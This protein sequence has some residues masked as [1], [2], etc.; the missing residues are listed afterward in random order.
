MKTVLKC[1]VTKIAESLRSS[2][3]NLPP[4]LLILFCFVKTRVEK[5]NFYCLVMLSDFHS[6]NTRVRLS[7][8]CSR[9]HRRSP[10]S[11]DI[12]MSSTSGGHESAPLFVMIIV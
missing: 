4:A 12:S 1:K 10:T 6:R 5:N 11:A 7:A 2:S 8:R 3:R 9:I